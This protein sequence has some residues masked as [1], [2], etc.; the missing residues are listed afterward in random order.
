M[1][2]FGII[3]VQE[4]YLKLSDWDS[5]IDWQD[6]LNKWRSEPAYSALQ[7]SFQ[8]TVDINLVK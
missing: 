5:V 6:Q 4:S 8:T 7:S 2:V 1:P 3:Q